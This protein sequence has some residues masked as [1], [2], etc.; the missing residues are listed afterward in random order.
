MSDLTGEGSDLPFAG[1]SL[2]YGLERRLRLAV[3]D[4]S[5]VLTFAILLSVDF[6][7]KF[8]NAQRLT[9]NAI[10]MLARWDL[11]GLLFLHAW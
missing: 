6:G 1:Y 8:R 9:L 3:T 7:V 11:L 5:L 10:P 2:T 4:W